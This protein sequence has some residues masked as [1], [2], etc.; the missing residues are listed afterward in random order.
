MSTEA[1]LGHHLQSLADGDL[2][3]IMADYREHSVLITPDGPLRGLAEIRRL[4]SKIVDVMLPPGSEFELVRKE[5][6]GE[7]AYTVWRGSSRNFN[8]LIGTDTFIIRDGVI[9]CQT[10][11]AQIQPKGLYKSQRPPPP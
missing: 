5:I 9:A 3:A 10:F 1:T 6:E 11:A 7:V 2:A 4:F 8:F